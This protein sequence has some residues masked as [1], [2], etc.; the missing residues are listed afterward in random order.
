M[1]L[2]DVFEAD[3]V[4]AKEGWH[5]IVLEAPEVEADAVV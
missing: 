1:D 4:R 3:I 5:E 2:S